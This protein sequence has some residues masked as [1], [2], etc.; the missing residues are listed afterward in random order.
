LIAACIGKRLLYSFIFSFFFFIMQWNKLNQVISNNVESAMIRLFWQNCHHIL[1]DLN[2]SITLQNDFTHFLKDL[3]TF[4][5]P[6]TLFHLFRM[7]FQ[8]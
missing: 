1:F 7:D 6:L 4:H 2:E 8:H 3:V 5:T